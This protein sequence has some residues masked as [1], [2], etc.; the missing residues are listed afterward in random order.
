MCARGVQLFRLY[1]MIPRGVVDCLGFHCPYI[2]VSLLPEGGDLQLRDLKSLMVPFA[3]L[4]QQK[5]TGKACVCHCLGDKVSLVLLWPKLWL[6]L[7]SVHR[8]RLMMNT[9]EHVKD[10]WWATTALCFSVDL[11][12]TTAAHFPST[13]SCRVL[14][15]LELSGQEKEW[16]QHK[17]WAPLR[18]WGGNPELT[19]Q[20]WLSPNSGILFLCLEGS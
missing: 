1:G 18:G 8:H 10:S 9:W 19:A 5:V 11:A 20:V 14:W 3:A 13:S 17:W 7:Y 16:R 15:T 12:Q 2:L 6:H 4:T